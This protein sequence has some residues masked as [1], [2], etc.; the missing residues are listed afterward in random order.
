MGKCS[1]PILSC[2]NFPPEYLHLNVS[3][4]PETSH[5]ENQA[6]RVPFSDRKLILHF[7]T[8]AENFYA[9]LTF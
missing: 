2:L 4:T 8:F 5:F 3:L 7:Y 9:N 1:V 6:H